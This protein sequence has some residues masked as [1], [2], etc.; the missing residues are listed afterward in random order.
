MTAR[1]AEPS[2]RKQP[3]S[4]YARESEIKT[5]DLLESS[6]LPSNL[7][8]AGGR[9]P[10][11]APPLGS[12]GRRAVARTPGEPCPGT[13]EDCR[14]ALAKRADQEAKAMA[15]I[16]E[17]QKKRVSETAEK[18]RTNQIEFDF[19]DFNSDEL[20]QL[21]SNKRHWE[22]RL[23]AIDRELKTEPE[24]IKAV[25]EVKAQGIEPVGL[26]YLWPVTG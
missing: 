7:A 15:E 9:H 22:K 19:G 17:L 12:G 14:V 25:Y 1:W 2:Q 11:E 13:G 6:L 20:R 8:R 23:A 5:L 16:L 21:E 18:F 4:P 3:L 24:C 26:I 10:G